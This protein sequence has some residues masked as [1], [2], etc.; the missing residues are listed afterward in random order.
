MLFRYS[1]LTFNSH[2]IHYDLPYARD[3]EMYPELVVHGPLMATLCM[4]L[5]A[6]HGRLRTFSFRGESAAYCDQPLYLGAK[7]DAKAG[8]LATIG[9]D[10]RRCLA[11]KASF[12]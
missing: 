8:E 3:E 5:A 6:S 2:R 7:F 11:A 12:D 4:Q 9:A 1:A 10:G